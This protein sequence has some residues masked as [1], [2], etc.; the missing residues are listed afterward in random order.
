[1]EAAV[2]SF[3]RELSIGVDESTWVP[4]LLTECRSP[5][6]CFVMAHGFAAGMDY[7]LMHELA[8]GLAHRG[9]ATLR[10][11]FPYM[12]SF[13]R[14]LDKPAVLHQ[15]VHASLRM[16]A[17]LMPGLPVFL[18]GRSFGSRI[19]TEAHAKHEFENLR[20]LICIGF[21]L[22]PAKNA[23]S[24]KARH[25]QTIADP[26]LIVQGTRDSLASQHLLEDVVAE[27]GEKATLRWIRGADHSFKQPNCSRRASGEV[28]Q[29]VG[30]V[31]DWVNDR[32]AA[33]QLI[34]CEKISA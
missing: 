31:A 14:I 16:A 19:A 34:G 5:K 6:A 9:I 29:I 3:T 7:P 10:F 20:G 12:Q 2:R 23:S 15:T 18:G 24:A 28:D 21:P 1:M 17:E 8:A 33:R 27:L 11:N 30:N 26:I 32:L 25:L 4:G 22:H 13:S